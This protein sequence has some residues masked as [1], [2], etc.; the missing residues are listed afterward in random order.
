M[1]YMQQR[2]PARPLV[3][4]GGGRVRVMGAA[5][6]LKPDDIRHVLRAVLWRLDIGND[7][8]AVAAWDKWVQDHAPKPMSWGPQRPLTASLREL[9]EGRIQ[10]G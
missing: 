4:F 5:G 3:V 1:R 2:P 10:V 9:L 7:P 8:S 6:R